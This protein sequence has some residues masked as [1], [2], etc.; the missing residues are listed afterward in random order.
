MFRT[1]GVAFLNGRNVGAVD[2][3][4]LMMA[5]CQEM[6]L[7]RADMSTSARILRLVAVL[8]ASRSDWVS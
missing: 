4:K 8:V 5:C 3:R 1:S 7:K 6:L 2:L